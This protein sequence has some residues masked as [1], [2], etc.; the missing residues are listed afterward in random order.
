VR[1]RENGG[2]T[3]TIEKRKLALMKARLAHPEQVIARS[4]VSN[5]IRAGRLI[6]Q[7]CIV[8]G[9]KAQAHHDD[10]SKPLDVIWLCPAH[11]M[12]RHRQQR[13]QEIRQRFKNNDLHIHD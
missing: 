10:Y 5:A 3:T 2:G 4:A 9:K 6:R 7:S 13:E 11:H 1:Q 8:C 12:E